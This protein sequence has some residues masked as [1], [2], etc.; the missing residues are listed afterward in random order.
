[1]IDKNIWEILFAIIFLFIFAGALGIIV[2]KFKAGWG[3]LK[4]KKLKKYWD[5]REK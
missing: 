4:D 3:K 2:E 1:M 5:E